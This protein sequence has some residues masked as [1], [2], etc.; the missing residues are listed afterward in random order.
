MYEEREGLYNVFSSSDIN[1]NFSSLLQGLTAGHT[2]NFSYQSNENVQSVTTSLTYDQISN[3]AAANSAHLIY[4]SSTQKLAV[5]IN[6]SENDDTLDG[7][8]GDD[9]I[10]ADAGDDVINGGDGNDKLYG[11]DG[12]DTIH[13][14]DGND[15]LWGHGDDDDLFGDAG[16]DWISGGAGDDEIWGS[17][18]ADQIFGGNDDDILNGGDGNDEIWGGAGDDTLN[19]DTDLNATRLTDILSNDGQ[20]SLFYDGNDTGITAHGLLD[21]QQVISITNPSDSAVSISLFT[22]GWNWYDNYTIDANSEFYILLPDS[23]GNYTAKIGWGTTDTDQ[24]LDTSFTS[25]ITITIESETQLAGD[26]SLFG[27]D[28]DD[29][30]YGHAGN[31]ILNG[32]DGN[33]E[34]WG[35]DG[36]DSI[37]AS[38]GNDTING[39]DDNDTLFLPATLQMFNIGASHLTA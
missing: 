10:Y 14:N 12:D 27:G 8:D 35:G 15:S 39:G 31:D 22:N 23:T 5:V 3:Y 36:D 33:D 30:L 2:Y 21:G 34:I 11:N 9:R 29:I 32:G 17:D 7:I 13:G 26:D 16:N 1:H 25:D 18:G 6:A 37:Y 24:R 20:T 19:G 4:N 38:S 28:G